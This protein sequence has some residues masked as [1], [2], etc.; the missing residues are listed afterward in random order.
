[1]G[2]GIR[3]RDG[4]GEWIWVGGVRGAWGGGSA[5]RGLGVMGAREGLRVGGLRDRAWVGRRREGLGVVG[6]T[7]GTVEGG[8]R[9]ERGWGAGWPRERSWGWVAG[10]RG[11][12]AAA[13]ACSGYEHI[14]HSI[15]GVRIDNSYNEVGALAAMVVGYRLLAYLSL[16][17]MKL[18]PGA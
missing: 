18:H 3:A 11:W 9:R 8:G 13:T 12:V 17:R 10:A 14:S 7:R 5:A 4:E 6:V 1:M 16:R 2:L 15:N